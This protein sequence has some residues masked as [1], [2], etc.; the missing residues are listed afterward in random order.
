MRNPQFREIPCS[1][2]RGGN[3]KS[4]RLEEWNKVLLKREGAKDAK[5]MV[6][7]VAFVTK[8]PY[9]RCAEKFSN[10]NI[11]R[12][13][14]PGD[15]LN[16]GGFLCTMPSLFQSEGFI[17]WNGGGLNRFGWPLGRIVGMAIV[18]SVTNSTQLPAMN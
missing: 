4:G 15:R 10:F 3:W 16:S 1:F 13:K 6:F 12:R 5:I 7:R 18:N 11:P 17:L 9:N 14:I 8:N 2:E